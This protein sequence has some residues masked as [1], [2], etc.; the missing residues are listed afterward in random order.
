MR[1][2]KEYRLDDKEVVIN[3]VGDSIMVTPKESLPKDFFSGIS[4][5]T[6]DYSEGFGTE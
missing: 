2:P 3:K 5:L 1:I 4:I 6:D